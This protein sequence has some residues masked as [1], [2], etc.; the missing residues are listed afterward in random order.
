M[1][2]KVKKWKVSQS[3]FIVLTLLYAALNLYTA[4]PFVNN[5]VAATLRPPKLQ[6]ELGKRAATG[7]TNASAWEWELVSRLDRIQ[8][9]CVSESSKS[10]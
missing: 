8:N 7:G 4:I 1:G 2:H 9:I 6:D 10:K 5:T 3:S